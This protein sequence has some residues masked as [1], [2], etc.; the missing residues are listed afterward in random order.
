M[1]DFMKKTFFWACSLL[2]LSLMAQSQKPNIILL[3]ADDL[4]YG[5]L[6]CYGATRV[7]TPEVDRLAEGGVQFTNMHACAST[8]TPSRY[9]LL[10]GEYPFR[11]R[12]TDVAA[13]NAAMIIKPSQTTVADL[14]KR[15]GY[16]T[17]A[18]GK[19]HLGL[20]SRTAEQDWNGTIDQTPADLGFD[21]HYIMAATA[22][23]VPCVFIENGRIA[24]YDASAPVSV[25]YEQNFDQEPTGKTHPELLTKLRPSHGHDQS[26]VNGISRIGYMKGGGKALWQDEN[27]ADSI[28]RHAVDFIDRHQQDPFFM[29]L[30]T[31]D[32]H[33]PR[34]PHERFRGKSPMGLRGEAILQFDWTVGQVMAALRERG[35]EE[36]TLIIVT[37]DNGPVLDDGYDD[38]AIALAGD[39][40]PGGPW[41]GAKY[42]AY[43]A[44]SVVPFIVYWP[45]GAARGLKSDA[46]GS[47][48]DVPAT[49]AALTGA[50]I[51]EDEA[52]D[53]QNHLTTWTGKDRKPREYAVSMANN[54]SLVLRTQRYKFISPSDG[55]PMIP[56]G[57][58]IETG[59]RPYVQ[60][61]D[62]SKDVYE[63]KNIA[64][65]N[66]QVMQKMQR[67]LGKIRGGKP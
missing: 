47:L 39:H 17:G 62:M 2:P 4:G 59:Y 29:Y 64:K 34:L 56:W 58:K 24:Q 20:G 3:V 27:I 49:L 63:E 48:I 37:S 6:S 50:K 16:V 35:L 51:E 5:D 67:L 25:S 65:D 10:T 61:F 21:C 7:R 53:S 26:I 9:A 23:R 52:H 55:Q 42:S 54:R 66:P 28:V 18:F 11:R 22:D 60:L 1:F 40:R 19:W 57:P 45:A 38:Q 46:L 44:G 36:N 41:R 30:C 43:E 33:V 12:G 8:S 31:N 15:S 14:M 32:V 13:G